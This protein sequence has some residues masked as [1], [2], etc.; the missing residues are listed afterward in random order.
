MR[1]AAL[2]GAG[3]TDAGGIDDHIQAVNKPA[4][5]RRSNRGRVFIVFERVYRDPQRFRSAHCTPGSITSKG[6]AHI[7]RLVVACNGDIGTIADGSC[8]SRSRREEELMRFHHD[9]ER[10]R[11]R[12]QPPSARRVAAERSGL[13][14]RYHF[15][16]RPASHGLSAPRIRCRSTATLVPISPLQ[17]TRSLR[18]RRTG[19]GR[20]E[21]E[22]RTCHEHI[23]PISQNRACCCRRR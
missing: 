17:A 16:V 1:G 23:E 7:E 9:D 20:I 22:D 4:T 12:R 3:A 6:I 13:R 19:I 14:C 10:Q 2:A 8:Q 5:A 21:I 11:D 15:I 18:G